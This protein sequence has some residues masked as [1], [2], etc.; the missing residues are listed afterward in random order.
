MEAIKT[1]VLTNAKAFT[2][3]LIGGLVTYCA[4]KG[5]TIGSDT[6]LALVTVVS[7]LVTALTVWLVPNKK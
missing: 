5:I 1:L 3:L 4:A 2:G 6:Q 7:G